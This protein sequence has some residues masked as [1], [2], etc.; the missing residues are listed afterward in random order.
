M[1]NLIQVTPEQLR[2]NGTSFMQYSEEVGSVVENTQSLTNQMAELWKGAASDE[3][4]AQ[5]NELKPKMDQF[6]QLL[7]DIGVQVQKVGD[8]LENADQEVA[9]G[10]RG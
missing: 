4:I 10:I 9:K 7:H 3:F 6:T 5:Y 1:S 8:A 2:E